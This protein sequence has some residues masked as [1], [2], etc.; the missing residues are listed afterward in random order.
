MIAH[1]GKD[2]LALE[3]VGPTAGPWPALATAASFGIW[4]TSR[5][6]N[7]A[8]DPPGLDKPDSG[9]AVSMTA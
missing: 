7:S 8:S 1:Q 6:G 5:D 9:G 3:A 2:R 4:R